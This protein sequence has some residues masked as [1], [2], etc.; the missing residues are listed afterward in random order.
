MPFTF[1]AGTDIRKVRLLIPD[2]IEAEAI[3]QD[4]EIEE[5]LELEGGNVKRAA[6]LALETIAVDEALVQKALD[7]PDLKTDGAKTADVLLKRARMLREQ[8]TSEK[9]M[10]V[11]GQFGWA[12]VVYDDFSARER[13]RNQG[14]RGGF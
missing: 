9:E 12:E 2:R 13:I 10:D 3:F 8:A 7:L 6:A 11:E 5:F 4:D 1:D 14:L